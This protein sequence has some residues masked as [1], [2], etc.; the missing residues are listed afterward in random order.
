MTLHSLLLRAKSLDDHHYGCL[1][2]L[3]LYLIIRE[4]EQEQETEREKERE[5]KDAH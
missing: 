2:F 1:P 5:G 4:A 3:G